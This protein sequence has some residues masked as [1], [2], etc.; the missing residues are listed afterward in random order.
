MDSESITDRVTKLIEAREVINKIVPE[1]DSSH[2]V[3][4][5]CHH[6][7]AENWDHSQAIQALQT[8]VARINKAITLVQLSGDKASHGVETGTELQE[9][10]AVQTTTDSREASNRPRIHFLGR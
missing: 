8:A 5:E 7:R 1:L 6:N 4:P 3:C 2:S 9:A 10:I